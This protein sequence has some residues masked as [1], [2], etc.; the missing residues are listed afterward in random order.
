[1]ALPFRQ[2]F[3]EEEMGRMTDRQGNA[4]RWA[5]FG[6][7]AAALAATMSYSTGIGA[8]HPLRYRGATNGSGSS[9]NLVD[10]GGRIAPTSHTYAIYWGPQSSWPSDVFTGIGTMFSG[11]N[12]SGLFNIGAQYM[13]GASL[14]TSYGGDKFDASAPPKRVGASTLGAEVQKEYGSSLDPNGIYFVYTSNFPRGGGFCAWHSFTTVGGQNVAVAYMP[15]TNGVAGCD[16]GTQYG[17][18]AHSEALR[19]L[20]NVTSHE[21]MEAITDLW[22]ANGS[23]AWIDQS[24]SEIGDKCAWQFNATV[25]LP[26]N[27]SKWILQEEWSNAISGCSQG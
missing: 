5:R 13:R 23:Y 22:P 26:S 15:N 17:D 4:R 11:L 24:G 8:A 20:A 14:T 3:K 2:A 27:N 6:V 18:P 16:P 7:A 1:L 19:S 10:N 25:T 21:F 12:G 9:S